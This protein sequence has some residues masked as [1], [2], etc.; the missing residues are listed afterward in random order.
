M[1]TERGGREVNRNL[2]L[3]REETKKKKKGEMQS[4]GWVETVSQEESPGEGL[5]WVWV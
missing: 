3:E 1:L 4:R 5:A 2:C